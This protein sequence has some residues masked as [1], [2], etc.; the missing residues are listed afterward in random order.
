MELSPRL[1]QCLG[2]HQ[3]VTICRHCDRGNI[4]CSQVCASIARV[5]SL[6]RAGARYQ[7]TPNG[8]R[9]H[10]ARQA[11]YRKRHLK[12]VTHQGSL[13]S[14]QNAPIR[15]LENRPIKAEREQISPG[16]ICCFCNKPVSVW[17]RH[18]F[19]GGR[20]PKKLTK[21]QAYPQAP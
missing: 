16:F 14:T 7:T 19:L 9:H 21:S 1:Y 3:Q 5:L 15:L 17:F 11:L 8:K 12:K 2:C 20:V 10:A 4:Y 18:D 13:C 6:R